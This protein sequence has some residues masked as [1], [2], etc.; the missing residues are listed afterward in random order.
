MPCVSEQQSWG[1][2]VRCR[3]GGGGGG[4]E[5]GVIAPRRKDFC[6]YGIFFQSVAIG[7][8]LVVSCSQSEDNDLY[9]SV[10]RAL[11]TNI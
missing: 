11:N 7:E 10:I 5:G 2:T 6:L 3:Q 4:G 9:C 1:R 8:E